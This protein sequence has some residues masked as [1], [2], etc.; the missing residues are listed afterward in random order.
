MV[1]NLIKAKQI[2]A[3]LYSCKQ[4]NPRKLKVTTTFAKKP[5]IHLAPTTKVLNT[6][7]DK[8]NY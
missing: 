3:I 4:Y 6:K 5:L 7:Q 2:Q 1:D 8:Q